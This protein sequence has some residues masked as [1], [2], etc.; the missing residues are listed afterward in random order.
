[1]CPFLTLSP[2]THIYTYT[3][4]YIYTCIHI[5]AQNYVYM[6]VYMYVCMY[7]SIC[8]YIHIYIHMCTYIYIYI[9]VPIYLN[10]HTHTYMLPPIFFDIYI[11]IHIYIYTYTYTHAYTHTWNGIRVD[12]GSICTSC[13]SDENDLNNT[14]DIFASPRSK[15]Q[16][17]NKRVQGILNLASWPDQKLFNRFK[18][19]NRVFSPGGPETVGLTA[20][21]LSQH[22]VQH[23]LDSR[24]Y[25]EIDV[26][27][28]E[29]APQPMEAPQAWDA[30]GLAREPTPAWDRERAAWRVADGEPMVKAVGIRI[31][32]YQR[33]LTMAHLGDLELCQ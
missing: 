20:A 12:C 10:K 3:Y 19:F 24:M 5:Y 22:V 13:H 7:M 28:Y 9:C 17:L 30:L 31:G 33:A 1:M 2:A 21:A 16:D 14:I 23:L 8:T 29:E 32:G 26:C 25:T 18:P 11:Y 27:T 4:V 6:Y 15:V